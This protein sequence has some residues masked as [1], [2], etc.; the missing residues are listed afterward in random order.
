MFNLYS[1]I[2]NELGGPPSELIGPSY[3]VRVHKEDII[4]QVNRL[5][6]DYER[7]GNFPCKWMQEHRHYGKLR[8]GLSE[9]R[10]TP[11]IVTS[12]DCISLI[13]LDADKIVVFF[14]SSHASRLLPVDL[15]F[16]LLLQMDFNRLFSRDYV[17]YYLHF[18]SLHV[19]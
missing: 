16:L 5:K 15:S 19:Y 17:D 11:R 8:K 2:R 12:S 6:Q 14:R 18:G 3:K 10:E 7:D 13:S 9:S 4:D 1:K